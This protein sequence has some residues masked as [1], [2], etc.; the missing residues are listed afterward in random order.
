ML[1]TFIFLLL[2]TWL[3]THAEA[4]QLWGELRSGKYPVGYRLIRERDSMRGNRMMCVNVWYPAISDAIPPLPFREYLA[5]GVINSSFDNATE[6][7]KKAVF[8]DFKRKL[9]TRWVSGVDLSIPSDRFEAAL[10]L[11][12]G[13]GLSRP[14]AKGRFPV[15][16]MSARPESL[17]VTA[18]YLAS[19]GF[20]AVVIHT[21]YD[22]VQPPDS[23]LYKTATD[24]LMW[25]LNYVS[26]LENSDADRVACLGFGGGIQPAFYLTMTTNRIRALVNLE[27]GVFG[28][29][30]KTDLSP[31][32]HPAKM[33]TPMLHIVTP[34]TRRDDDFRI[35]R[36]LSNT[37]IYRASLQND[38]LLHH[39]FSIFGRMINKGLGMAGE[40]AAYADA[41]FASAHRLI[42]QFLQGKFKPS[43]QYSPYIAI[44]KM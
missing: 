39:D 9:E 12:T 41:A 18:E 34:E 23:L 2:I 6:E 24:D 43:D 25:G 35:V 3:V 38:Q 20:V 33:K 5:A 8:D 7:E 44:D 19:N 37:V 27:G 15:V 28:P 16:L 11:P 13:A 22:Q 42:L 21:T 32:Y 30:S 4:Q 14:A 36:Q 31:D 10:D 1:R 17:S 26:K 29:R 40:R